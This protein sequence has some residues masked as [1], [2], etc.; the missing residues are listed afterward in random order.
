MAQKA[1]ELILMRQLASYLAV[2]IFLVDTDGNLLYYNEPAEHLLGR[3]YDETGEMPLAEWSTAF[4][5]TAEDGRPIPRE[6]L[7]LSIALQ[8]WRPT[9]RALV[10]RGF[11]GVARRIAVT[12]L[13]LE[14]QGRRRLGAVAIFWEE[15]VS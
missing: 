5:P 3:R 7:A 4:T 6:E 10:I 14:G 8:K 11:D 9:H 1:V 15:H 12:A 13:P 2:P